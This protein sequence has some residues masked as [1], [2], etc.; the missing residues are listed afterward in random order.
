MV[1]NILEEYAA[2]IFKAESVLRLK[3]MMVKYVQCRYVSCLGFTRY[4]TVSYICKLTREYH[5]SLLNFK[6]VSQRE[7]YRPTI[8][9]DTTWRGLNT[10]GSKKNPDPNTNT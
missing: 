10:N 3:V 4:V 6:T 1:T 9:K 8:S 5:N 7:I 2:P